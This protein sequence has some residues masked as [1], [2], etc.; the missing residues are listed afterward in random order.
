MNEELQRIQ[1]RARELARSG[2][3]KNWRPIA[4]ALQ[5]EADFTDAFQWI[6]SA[7]TRDELDRL[8]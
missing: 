8:V 7:S 5:F 1:D 4:F 2:E 3:Y 6:Y